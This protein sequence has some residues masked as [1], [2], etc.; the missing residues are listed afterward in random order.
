MKK[1][2]CMLV[3]AV[4]LLSLATLA[5]AQEKKYKIGVF[6]WH[7][8]ANDYLAFEGIRDGFKTAGVDCEFDIQKAFSDEDKTSEI[9]KGWVKQKPTLIYAMGTESCERLMK[10]V[11]D[12]PIVFT[13]VTNPVQSGIT[14]NWETSGRNIAGNSNWIPTE[15]IYKR[16]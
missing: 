12:T 8:S 11:K 14:P 5:G 9:I 3:I 2:L 15:Y 16:K 6:F 7:E 13:A 4:L 1:I 10:V